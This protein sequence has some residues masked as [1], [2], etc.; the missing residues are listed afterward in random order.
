MSNLIVDPNEYIEPAHDKFWDGHPTRRELQTTLHKIGL[1][2]TACFEAIDT[3][4][5]VMNCVCE[6]LNITR[7]ELDSF[8]AKKAEEAKAWHEAQAEAEKK[9]QENTNEPP[10]R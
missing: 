7:E 8:V 9:A 5:L 3:Q 10:N 2:Q 1:N 6:K 4:A